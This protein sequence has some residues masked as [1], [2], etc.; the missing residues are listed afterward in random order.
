MYD[1]AY[2]GNF[3]SSH[4]QTT[5]PFFPGSRYKSWFDGH[6]FAS[7]LFPAANGKSQESSSEAVNCYYGVY[8]WSLARNGA[9]SNPLDDTSSGT[10]FARLLLATEIIGAK[11]YWQMLPSSTS[12]QTVTSGNKTSTGSS[13]SPQLPQQ[14]VYGSQ[15]ASNLMVGNVGM[16]D[17]VCRTWFGK[18]L[19]YVHMINFLPVTSVTGELFTSA[20]ATQEYQSV[21]KSLEADPAW[22]GFV[23]ANHAISAPNMAWTDA[24]SV[25]SPQLDVGLSKS[26]LLFW[27]ATRKGFI[28][29]ESQQSSN[30]GQKNP[31][32]G[33]DSWNV[34]PSPG[35]VASSSDG[36][37]ST[38][39]KCAA[40]GLVGACCP[41]PGGSS[42]GTNFSTCIRLKLAKSFP[43]LRASCPLFRFASLKTGKQLPVS[44]LQLLVYPSPLTFFEFANGVRLLCAAV[45]ENKDGNASI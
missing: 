6:S 25:S 27:I 43:H 36:T 17:A 14:G 5:G 28:A 34:S 15:F 32:S 16:L 40:L 39:P 4:K 1:V 26:Q 29:P 7:G 35:P 30:Q 24:L 38:N 31:S 21:L 12:N 44:L 13:G 41:T 20:Y 23:I 11:T 37:C 8:L 42:L 10:D 9:L 3:A 2:Q 18:E 19:L 45:D 22:I 33:P